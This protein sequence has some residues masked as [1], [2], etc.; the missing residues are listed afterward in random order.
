MN[1]CAICEKTLG[2][3][4]ARKGKSACKKHQH[5]LDTVVPNKEDQGDVSSIH[6]MDANGDEV[7]IRSLGDVETAFLTMG[8]PVFL[9]R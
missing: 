3:N 5:I 2:L 1:R 9:V 8:D 6:Y 4:A 7:H